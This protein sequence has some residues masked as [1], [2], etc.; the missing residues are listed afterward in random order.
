MGRPEPTCGSMSGWAMLSTSARRAEASF[1]SP[2]SGR[3]CCSARESGRRLFWRCCTRWRRPAR[4]GRS[5]GCTRLA[6]GQHH[7]FAAEV[8]RLMLALTARPQLCLL[9]Q[10]GRARQ[11][12]RGFRRYRSP[13]AIGLRRGRHS[14]RGGCL[15]LRADSLHGRDERGARSLGR[16]A[17]ADSRRNLQR[18]RV[19]DSRCRR[20]SDASS[21]S[22]RATTP[23]PVRWY[24]SRAAASPHTGRRRPTR[25]FWSWP[26]RATS[27]SAGRAG[28]AFVTTVRAVWFRGRS[29]TD[30]SHS[31]SPPTATF[32]F[33]ARNRFA[34]SSSICEATARGFHARPARPQRNGACPAPLLCQQRTRRQNEQP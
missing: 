8:R 18:Q 24:R 2:E 25:A 19:D 31:T 9:Q 16:G 10:A 34:T 13:V 29:S 3:W 11:D 22:A 26:R 12:G 17:G 21:A 20:R 23:T 7:P 1:C 5:C 32:S 15:P 30:R 27:R 28:P 6:I 14:A 4:H 33:A